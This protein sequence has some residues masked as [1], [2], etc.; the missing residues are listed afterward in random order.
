[1][2]LQQHLLLPESTVEAVASTFK[3]LSDPTR[4]K[5]LYLLSQG[6]C[7]VTRISEELG[8]S[9][10]AVSHQLRL[11]KNLRLVKGRRE[12]QAVFYTCDDEHVITLLKQAI[13]HMEHE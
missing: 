8:M 7:T 4:I 13:H 3:V 10:S 9:P 5:L 6:E 11:L 1:M 2:D 12:G